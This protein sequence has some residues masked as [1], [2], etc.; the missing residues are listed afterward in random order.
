MFWAGELCPIVH[1]SR[2]WDK[3]E[4]E[5]GRGEEEFDKVGNVRAPVSSL[6]NRIYLFMFA[7][8]SSDTLNSNYSPWLLFTPWHF[9][10]FIICFIESIEIFL[11]CYVPQI[12]II[13]GSALDSD[14]KERKKSWQN[15]SQVKFP[16]KGWP[17][18]LSWESS[19]AEK[20][21]DMTSR[22]MSSPIT[23]RLSRELFRARRNLEGKIPPKSA[24]AF[25]TVM[26]AGLLPTW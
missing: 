23:N 17:M 21:L 7:F 8:L 3:E 18:L 6:A 5:K 22:L 2:L 13:T 16:R 24:L 25:T 20:H 9:T 15:S 26:T 4:N 12:T 11:H 14:R 19:P 10:H 1:L